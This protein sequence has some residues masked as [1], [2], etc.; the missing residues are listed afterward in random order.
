MKFLFVGTRAVLMKRLSEL[1]SRPDEV[2]PIKASSDTPNRSEST[3]SPPETN[4]LTSVTEVVE[5]AEATSTSGKKRK[6]NDLAQLDESSFQTPCGSP[7]KLLKKA[8]PSDII[9]AT[10][11]GVLAFEQQVL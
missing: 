2:Q 10:P 9:V 8:A 6:A 1:L 4:S 3:T 11:S 7:S 5:L